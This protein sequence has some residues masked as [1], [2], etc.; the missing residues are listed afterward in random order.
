MR[1]IINKRAVVVLILISML[2]NKSKTQI[3]PCPPNS[4]FMLCIP[5]KEGG[6]Y[7][8]CTCKPGFMV[9]IDKECEEIKVMQRKAK[10]VYAFIKPPTTQKR[11][12]FLS[13][14]TLKVGVFNNNILP[15]HL[16]IK[17]IPFKKEKMG[18]DRIIAPLSKR[19]FLD[20]KFGHAPI[21]YGY[22]VVSISP[23]A[24][25]TIKKL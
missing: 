25:V 11:I 16:S 13:G 20:S 23:V 4:I 15:V 17:S 8:G 18:R 14:Q 1:K 3:I 12:V 7:T 9:G 22:H 24:N 19:E 5:Y 10:T 21:G 6:C 2:P